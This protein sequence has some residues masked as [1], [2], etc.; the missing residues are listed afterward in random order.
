MNEFLESLARLPGVRFTALVTEDGV[1]VAVPGWKHELDVKKSRPQNGQDL[2][3]VDG[4]AAVSIGWLD[5]LTRCVA[6]LSWESPERVVLRAARGTLVMLRTANSV[7]I[8]VLDPG[9]DPEELKLPMDGVAARIQRALRGRG[10][11]STPEA[12]TKSEP[13]APPPAALPSN[14]EAARQ[15]MIDAVKLRLSSSNG[16]QESSGR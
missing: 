6:A 9:L 10:G 7:L 5:E 8:T 13:Q 11:A 16:S 15:H 2:D 1:P 14:S 12:P 4:A 3:E